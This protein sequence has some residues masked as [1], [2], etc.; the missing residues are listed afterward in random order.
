MVVVPLLL[1]RGYLTLCIVMQN[2][3]PKRNADPSTLLSDV[4]PKSNEV[5]L[6]SSRPKPAYKMY[7]T[8]EVGY[9]GHIPGG[10][11]Q[12]VWPE[13]KHGRREKVMI[14]TLANLP[15]VAMDKEH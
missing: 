4:T 8:G 11:V 2:S 1:Y 14:P 13:D 6:P 5:Y 10:Y 9:E 7:G 15:D 3:F 12:I